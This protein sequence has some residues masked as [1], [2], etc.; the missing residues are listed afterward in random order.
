MNAFAV[1]EGDWNNEPSSLK[2][3]HISFS[4][5][6]FGGKASRYDSIGG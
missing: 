5:T 6:Y 3:L 2:F 1:A 4:L